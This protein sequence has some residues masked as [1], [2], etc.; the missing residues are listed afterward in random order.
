MLPHGI[1]RFMAFSTLCRVSAPRVRAGPG[2]SIPRGTTLLTAPL[3]R[4]GRGLHNS[5]APRR[6]VFP[7]LFAANAREAAPPRHEFTQGAARRGGGDRQFRRRASGTCQDRRARAGAGPCRGRS[8]SG[9]YV[10]SSSG[11]H[12]AAS[13][14]PAAADLDRSQSRPVGQIR[15]RRRNCV[16]HGRSIARIDG[17]G[18]F[19]AYRLRTAQRPQYRG[20]SQL[21]LRTWAAK[22]RS[23]CSSD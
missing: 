14:C 1:P 8:G 6:N 18:V 15:H 17:R 16:S 5:V 3:T 9:F 12:S 22:E 23:M 11:P 10:R 20:G 13:R 19:S 7:P 21:L 4:R 2:F